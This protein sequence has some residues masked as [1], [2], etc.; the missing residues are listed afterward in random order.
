[1]GWR[2]G[3]GEGGGAR[4]SLLDFACYPCCEAHALFEAVVCVHKLIR[5]DVD[6]VRALGGV[7]GVA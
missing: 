4:D 2:L 7:E 3:G 1:M 6:V 5:D